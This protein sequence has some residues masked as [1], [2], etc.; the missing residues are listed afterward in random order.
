MESMGYIA[1][2]ADAHD[3]RMVR[4]YLTEEGRRCADDLKQFLDEMD[5]IIYRGFSQTE[6]ALLRRF[7]LTMRDNLL[8]VEEFEGMDVCEVMKKTRKESLT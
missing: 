2:V 5:R 1:K 7:S 4:V 8:D 6:R 3:Q